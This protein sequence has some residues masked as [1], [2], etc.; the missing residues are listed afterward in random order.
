MTTKLFKTIA[1]LPASHFNA[2][3]KRV[4]TDYID[5]IEQMVFMFDTDKKRQ[6][7]IAKLVKMGVAK[8][9]MSFAEGYNNNFAIFIDQFIPG[10]DPIDFF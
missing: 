8:S 7:A 4:D 3:E 5:A 2:V 10:C 6:A 9:D 1:Q